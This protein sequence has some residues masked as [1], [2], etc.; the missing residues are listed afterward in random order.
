MKN[1]W[2]VRRKG[3][4]FYKV[5]ASISLK[6]YLL[7]L[8]TS[9]PSRGMDPICINAIIN[10]IWLIILHIS[11]IWII[12]SHLNEIVI[13]QIKNFWKSIFMCSFYI[14]LNLLQHKFMLSAVSN[15]HASRLMRPAFWRGGAQR[16]LEER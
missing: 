1:N 12:A 2:A 14:T 16:S 15:F 8:R 4:Y 6:I 10:R 5:V 7:C 9:R 11:M 13:T 3:T